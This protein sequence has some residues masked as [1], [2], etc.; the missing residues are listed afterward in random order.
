MMK[1]STAERICNAGI[2]SLF[3]LCIIAMG[4]GIAVKSLWIDEAVFA[5]NVRNFP[6]GM[7]SQVAPSPPLLYLLTYILVCFLGKSEW[8]YRLIPFISGV[9]GLAIL[10]YFLR[11]LYARVPAIL[12]CFL[13]AISEP[14]IWYSGAAHPYSVDFFCS[15]L[16]LFVM[17]H[18]L[19]ERCQKTWFLWVFVAS[20]CLPISFTSLFVFLAF[21]GVIILHDLANKNVKASMREIIGAIV[22]FGI[23]VSLIFFV[24]SRLTAERLDLDAWSSFFPHSMNPSSLI[25]WLFYNTSDMLGYFFWNDLIQKKLP[26]HFTSMSGGLVGFF[27]ALVGTAWLVQKRRVLLMLLCWS[28]I[29]ITICLSILGKWPYGAVRTMIFS[30]PFAIVL[31][32]AGLEA[33]LL[34]AKTRMSRIII[35][36]ACFILLSSFPVRFRNVLTPPKDSMEA[37]KTLSKEIRPQIKPEDTFI[38]YYGAGAAF[39][40]YFSEFIEIATIQ[41]FNHRKNSA[42]QEELVMSAML[43]GKSRVWLIFSHVLSHLKKEEEWM[44]SVARRHREFMSVYSA[45]GCRAY[46]LFRK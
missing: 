5:E 24:Y 41:P 12:S 29:M 34:S 14:L 8:V 1:A 11:R 46:L 43:N 23:A 36:C 32:G 25:Y 35:V 20:I 13:L 15:V 4:K 27:L 28:P 17:M 40:F 44:V 16:L 42:L 22:P 26:Q 30:L 7:F 39:K 19:Q 2:C 45:P 9:L 38:V 18:Y 31:I 3:I 10:F 37:M 33:V 21:T 6:G